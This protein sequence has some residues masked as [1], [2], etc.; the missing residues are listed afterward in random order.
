MGLLHCESHVATVHAVHQ[1][2]ISSSCAGANT[3]ARYPERHQTIGQA[4]RAGGSNGVERN[5]VL[6]LRVP[7]IFDQTSG[8]AFVLSRLSQS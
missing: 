7:V 4:Q 1:A 5:C 2:F 6:K 3:V 8:T